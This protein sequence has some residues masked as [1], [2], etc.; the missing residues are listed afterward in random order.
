MATTYSGPSAHD[1]IQNHT[2]AKEIIARS[3]DPGP[4]LDASELALLKRFVADPSSKDEMLKDLGMKNLAG[5]KLVPKPRARAAW[6]ATLLPSR[7]P[8]SRS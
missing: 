6:S 1:M 3:N 5:S 7:Q 8:V 4:V 2:L